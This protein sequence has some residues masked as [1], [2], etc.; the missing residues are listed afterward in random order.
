M[1]VSLLNDVRSLGPKGAIVD[2]PEGYARSFLFPEHLAVLASKSVVAADK[3]LDDR[4]KESKAEREERELAGEIDGLE[5]VRLVKQEKGLPASAVGREDVKQGL[6]EL[7]FKVP[8]DFIGL[9][10]PLKEFGTFDVPVTFPSG[11]ESQLSVIIE[12]A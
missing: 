10:K 12:A 9:K 4:P 7:G 6:K 5:I 2:V 8:L 11:F 1:L 3:A